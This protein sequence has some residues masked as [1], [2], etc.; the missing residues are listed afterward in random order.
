MARIP[1]GATKSLLIRPY[2]AEKVSN[3]GLS[4]HEYLLYTTRDTKWL[5]L[6]S[7]KLNLKSSEASGA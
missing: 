2:R 3:S 6:D 4:L 1:G 5:K 7:H